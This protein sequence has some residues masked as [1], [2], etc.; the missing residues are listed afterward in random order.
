MWGI[1]G[2][3]SGTWDDT[4]Y[5]AKRYSD[6]Y[7]RNTLSVTS[8]N[9]EGTTNLLLCVAG[10][11]G[12]QGRSDAQELLSAHLRRL[13]FLEWFLSC[14]HWSRRYLVTSVGEQLEQFNSHLPKYLTPFCFV[15]AVRIEPTMHTVVWIAA[16]M[17]C[18]VRQPGEAKR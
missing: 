17:F 14:R 9:S 4:T 10:L 5:T 15:K 6:G 3:K 2:P 16:S 7:A 18:F 12:G 13:E 1:S 8:D 11:K